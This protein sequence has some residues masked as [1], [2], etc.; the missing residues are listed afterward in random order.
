MVLAVAAVLPLA[1]RWV[2][3]LRDP[4]TVVIYWIYPESHTHFDGLLCGVLLAY[5][6]VYQREAVGRVVGR[7]GPAGWIAA[8]GCFAAAFWWGG[9]IS[10]GFFPVVLQFFVLAIG[11]SLL[12]LNGLY[13]NNRVTR[14]LAHPVWYPV[15]RVSYG[16]YLIHLFPLF[17]VLGWWPHAVYG[18]WGAVAS[19][20]GFTAVVTLLTTLSAAF[21]FLVLERPMLDWGARLSRRYTPDADMVRPAPAP[22]S[23]AGTGRS[24]EA[25]IA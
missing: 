17:W 11:S 7:L 1:A 10:P 13:L 2:L 20:L 14:F 25:G 19:L 21:L 18:T 24:P 4:K 5:G 6:Y 12:L 23:I 3:F 9:L 15:A 8:L 22:Q 16:I